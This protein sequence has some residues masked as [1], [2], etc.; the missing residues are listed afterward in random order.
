MLN[1]QQL[2]GRQK[3]LKIYL[4]TCAAIGVVM[5]VCFLF[6]VFSFKAGMMLT[7]ALLLITLLLSRALSVSINC[8]QKEES[9]ANSTG[10]SRG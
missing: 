5:A 4:W 8:V 7:T 2:G 3:R 1:D 9:R 10:E 6:E